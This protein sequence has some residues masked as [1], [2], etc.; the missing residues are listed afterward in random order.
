[1]GVYNVITAHIR[2]G[3]GRQGLRKT[4]VIVLN[5]TGRH[6]KLVSKIDKPKIA[7]V[8]GHVVRRKEV[9][10]LILTGK[11]KGRRATT[12]SDVNG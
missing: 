7:L 9:L 2:I 11:I 8:L 12:V 4:N 6:A 5:E 3:L 1:M 10:P